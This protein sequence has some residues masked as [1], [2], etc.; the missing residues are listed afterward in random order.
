MAQG[1]RTTEPLRSERRWQSTVQQG[2]LDSWTLATATSARFASHVTLARRPAAAVTLAATL[3]EGQRSAAF[4]ALDGEVLGGVVEVA[5]GG[6]VFEIGDFGFEGRDLVAGAGGVDG[7]FDG[8]EGLELLH[9][10]GV[11]FV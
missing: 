6:G 7:G 11:G 1:L 10:A 4:G 2:R 9:R 8:F 5:G 3:L